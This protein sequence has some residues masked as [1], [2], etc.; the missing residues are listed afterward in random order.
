MLE[1]NLLLAHQN[2]SLVCEGRTNP[3]PSVILKCLCCLKW[4]AF[5]QSEGFVFL[6]FFCTYLMFLFCTMI[7]SKTGLHQSLR[8]YAVIFLFR[9][10]WPE[11]EHTAIQQH[12]TDHVCAAKLWSPLNP[13]AVMWSGCSFLLPTV[14]WHV[15]FGLLC[16][17][18]LMACH[19]FVANYRV[20]SCERMF[21]KTHREPLMP[22]FVCTCLFL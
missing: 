15:T 14:H 19:L 22:I 13:A 20:V 4:K 7:L 21:L 8:T 3:T 5:S 2:S 18:C 16:L 1:R 12:V 11:V 6:M 10:Y 17:H 9:F